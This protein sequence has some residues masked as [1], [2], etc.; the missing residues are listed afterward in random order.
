MVAHQTLDLP[1]LPQLPALPAAAVASV[2]PPARRSC[3]RCPRPARRWGRAPRLSVPGLIA[4]SARPRAFPAAVPCACLRRLAPHSRSTTR[5]RGVGTRAAVRHAKTETHRHA[6]HEFRI[7]RALA[8]AAALAAIFPAARA[9]QAPAFDMDP[10]VITAVAPDSPLTFITNPKTP[11]QLPASD[12][13]DYLKTI[14]G[15]SAIR[16]GGTNGDPVL[17]GM[18]GSRLNILTNGSSMPGACP[19]RMD[20]QLLYLAR[21]L[22]PAH[23]HQG[24]ADRAVGPRRLGRHRALRPRHAAR[25]TESRRALR[26]QRLAARSA[27]TTRRPTSPPAMKASTC[28]SPATTRTRK[29]T[30]TATACAC[31]RAGTS[32]T[33]TWP[34]AS[35]RT[36]TRCSS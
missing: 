11:R 23:R 6:E 29:T 18:F 28:A 17:R 22:R 31:P 25:F 13:T 7:P 12:G 2:A 8:L 35:R 30:R 5:A 27:A 26:R 10:V 3:R 14:P 34:W 24:T 20:A 33:P 4:R 15:F 1:P 36:P 21:D 32:G 19:G 16:N 9:Q